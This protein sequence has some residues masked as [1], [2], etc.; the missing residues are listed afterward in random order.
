MRRCVQFFF[1]FCIAF[2]SAPQAYA[3]RKD[4]TKHGIQIHSHGCEP[5]GAVLHRSNVV[6]V[7]ANETFSNGMN[8]A[9]I[10][11]P[12]SPSSMVGTSSFIR[13]PIEYHSQFYSIKRV[14]FIGNSY[15]SVNNLPSIF[16]SIVKNSG[17][18]I[19]IV[20]A[21]TPGGINF[22]GHLYHP[23]TLAA[24]DVGNW[25]I[26]VLQNQSQEPA[27]AEIDLLRQAEM[28]QSAAALCQRIRKKSPNVRIVFYETWARHSNYWVNNM[29][30]AEG[31][32]PK[33]MQ[34]RLRKWYGIVARNNNATVASVGDA[35]EY[36]YNKQN[37][38]R[39]HA[40]D[41]SHPMFAGSYLAGLML[42]GII[43]NKPV[44]NISWNGS[45]TANVAK[46]L[47]TAA[48]HT[49]AKTKSKGLHVRPNN[50]YLRGQE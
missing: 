45:L 27:F 15:T 5:T 13:M 38:L 25:N 30:M 2:L 39:L 17:N 37:P 23:K 19:P 24:I 44:A 35:W 50:E 18:H 4:C 11:V 48:T 32:N 40:S 46:Q 41:N 9:G 22:R 31:A 16:G 10:D 49:L 33:E 21:V 29:P 34:A 20:S 14:L 42:F 43:Y 1:V 47:R 26:V 12:N 3:S 8:L 7:H 36:H 6:G 28:V